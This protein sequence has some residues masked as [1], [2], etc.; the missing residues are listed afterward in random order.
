MT[1]LPFSNLLKLLFKLTLIPTL[2]LNNGSS[3]FLFFN[4]SL[5]VCLL[6]CAYFF[7]LSFKTSLLF[8][9]YILPF[10]DIDFLF[11]NLD[12]LLYSW[13]RSLLLWY[14]FLLVSLIFSPCSA[15]LALLYSLIRS[16]LI[17]LLWYSAR[18]SFE[19]ALQDAVWLSTEAMFLWNSVISF[20]VSQ[21]LQ[22][23]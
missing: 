5:W 16:L 14:I 10:S 4:H 3:A 15:S 18:C 6:L 19:Q 23:L 11:F 22:T 21:V 1:L 9:L 8:S 20:S 13:K 17:V 2:N 12:F 7:F